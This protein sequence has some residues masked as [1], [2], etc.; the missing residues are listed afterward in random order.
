MPTPA[1]TVEDLATGFIITLAGI[2]TEGF[3]GEGG[4]ATAAELIFPTGTAVDGAGN[5]YIADRTVI[6]RIVA[7]TGIIAAVA[8]EIDPEGM[9]PAE[10]GR[11][12]DP[13]ALVLAEPF[14]LVAGG[15]SGTVQ[16]LRQGW[17]EVVAG[18]YPQPVAQANLARYRDSSF[19]HVGG[20]VD[21]ADEN[22][23]TIAPLAGDGIAGFADGPAAEAR[24]RSPTGLYLDEAS[25]MLYVADTGNQVVRVIDL[26][27]QMVDTIAGKPETLGF[28]GDGGDALLALLYQPKAITRCG[29]GDLFIADTGNHRVRRIDT[30]GQITTVLGDG[31]AASSGEGGPADTFPVDTPV[32]L[33]CDG[34]GNVFSTSRTTVRMIEADDTSMVDGTGD[35]QTIFA[36]SPEYPTYCLTAIAAVDD[37]T[38]W[39]TDACSGMLLELWRQPLP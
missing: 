9:G 18:R 11:F 2:G 26:S 1:T 15:S 8:G 10:S 19:G 21:P 4:P 37:E 35:V 12:A 27:T 30:A 33:A 6:R 25:Q 20:V 29:N 17:L 38:L 14:A 28:F 13:R 39:V 34:F 36:A 16:T 5:V 22:G 31:I 24:F 3:S 23:W 7:G 32:G